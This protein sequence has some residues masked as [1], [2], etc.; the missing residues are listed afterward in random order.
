MMFLG[1]IRFFLM[2]GMWVL[3]KGGCFLYVLVHIVLLTLC[4]NAGS[5]FSCF[6]DIRVSLFL[7]LNKLAIENQEE[8][9]V[10]R[11]RQKKVMVCALLWNR[12]EYSYIA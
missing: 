5:A 10:V 3:C 6:P 8:V 11:A 9:G 4:S 2:L 7:L 1:F 12:A